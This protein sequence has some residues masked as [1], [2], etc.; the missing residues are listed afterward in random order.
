[1]NKFLYKK[2]RVWVMGFISEGSI[3]RHCLYKIYN[4]EINKSMRKY[5][6]YTEDLN[7]ISKQF[8]QGIFNSIR[9]E[10]IG[11]P[12]SALIKELNTPHK[13]V[14]KYGLS[15]NFT[16]VNVEFGGGDKYFDYIRVEGY[17]SGDNTLEFVK[18]N[19][20]KILK[21]YLDSIMNTRRW[22]NLDIPINVLKLTDLILTRS[23]I[24]VA[25]FSVKETSQS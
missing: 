11:E 9:N 19:K 2:C 14:Y 7:K 22:K 15:N 13:I 23:N 21:M 6:N 1:M 20:N 8:I 24:L 3:S 4:D 25:T 16:K 5:L 17:I 12:I 18:C 10:L